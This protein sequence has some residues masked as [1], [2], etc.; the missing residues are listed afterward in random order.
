MAE[1]RKGRKV[2]STETK[3]GGKVICWEKRQAR[4]NKWDGGWSCGR[5]CNL[6]GSEAGGEREMEE[7]D[8]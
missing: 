1:Q 3:N 4:R 6:E 7:K 8:N 2:R 5:E